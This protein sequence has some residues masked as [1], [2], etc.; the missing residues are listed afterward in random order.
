[1]AEFLAVG[2][3]WGSGDGGCHGGSCS[4]WWVE[5]ELQRAAS[6]QTDGYETNTNPEFEISKS[7]CAERQEKKMKGVKVDG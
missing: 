6:E 3:G 4:E 2:G 1:M 5:M 7:A